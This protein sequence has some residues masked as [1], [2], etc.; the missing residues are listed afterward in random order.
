MTDRSGCV[1]LTDTP[2]WANSAAMTIAGIDNDTPDPVGGKIL[3]DDNG[4]ATGIFIDKA[5]D[6]I[7]QHLPAPTKSDYRAALLERR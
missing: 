1:V 7:E 4:Q 6:L 5:M 3:R 2:G